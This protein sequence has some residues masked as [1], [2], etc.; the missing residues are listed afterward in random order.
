MKWFRG[1]SLGFSTWGNMVLAE[2]W[3]FDM[4]VTLSVAYSRTR[5]KSGLYWFSFPGLS[6]Q[7]CRRLWRCTWLVSLN[8]QTCALSIIPKDMQLARHK[9]GG[10]YPI[11]TSLSVK[12]NIH[13][14]EKG[15]EKPSKKKTSEEEKL[16]AP[17]TSPRG[18]P[19]RDNGALLLGANPPHMDQAPVVWQLCP[20]VFTS[21][22]SSLQ[23]HP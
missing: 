18:Q 12:E 22:A 11:E 14:S 4:P 15:K 10:P 17:L 5:A 3:S 9:R 13:Q 6:S 23:G 1:T 21:S 2:H 16:E 8:T 7:H 20:S 19:D